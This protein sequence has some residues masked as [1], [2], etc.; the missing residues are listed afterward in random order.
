MIRIEGQGEGL[1]DLA[2]RSML[3]ILY[4]KRPLTAW[5][6]SRLV[7]IE[8][9]V[10]SLED[11]DI[12][13]IEDVLSACAGLLV[14]DEHSGIVRLA[15]FTVQEFFDHRPEYFPDALATVAHTCVLYLTLPF[16]GSRAQ[17]L[18]RHFWDLVSDR[19][20]THSDSKHPYDP[21]NIDGK[22][23]VC[24]VSLKLLS[25][26]LRNRLLPYVL[27]HWVL[28]VKDGKME[29]DA[30][31]LELLESSYVRMFC[32]LHT[33]NS[34]ASDPDHEFAD[35]F[36]INESL[37]HSPTLLSFSNWEDH[38]CKGIHLAAHCGFENALSEFIRRGAVVHMEDGNGSTAL[39]Y[40][41][42]HGHLNALMVL[43]ESDPD[44]DLNSA[45]RDCNTA[46]HIAVLSEQENIVKFLLEPGRSINP[47]LRNKKGR[48]PFVEACLFKRDRL[49][50]YRYTGSLKILLLLI[51]STS[52]NIHEELIRESE[53]PDQSLRSL[54][55]LLGL[56]APKRR[57]LKALLQSSAPASARNLL[58]YSAFIVRFSMVENAIDMPR[59]IRQDWIAIIVLT[60]ITEIFKENA[61][62]H[63]RKN[64][65][66]SA[67]TANQ[68]VFAKISD[69]F[70]RSAQNTFQII[71][72]Q[73]LN[74]LLDSIIKEA[75]SPSLTETEARGFYG[76]NL[77]GT[78]FYG[79][80]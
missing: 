73:D 30:L 20:P 9:G 77:Y 22:F 23:G 51:E 79:T 38:P 36:F 71:A 34:Q 76:N 3:W 52:V 66:Y 41:A 53:N 42:A 47:N 80:H 56:Y 13:E 63:A 26:S 17:A 60:L 59:E 44:I 39:H 11:D 70:A 61:R 35:L 49:S 37:G 27:E 4:A 10:S 16:I 54:E 24:L 8:E 69:V 74:R 29:A 15:H 64:Q 14:S 68:M 12:P 18:S 50:R 55:E 21:Y 46:L 58:L 40:A 2:K 5:E 6:L 67:E 33:L 28:H 72:K 43:T 45:N 78:H 48:T 1:H 25:R 75:L 57:I 62:T 31:T 32:W 19:G 7:A 65:S